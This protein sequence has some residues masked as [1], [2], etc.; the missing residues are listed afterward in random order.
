[1]T[2]TN[3]IARIKVWTRFVGNDARNA[4]HACRAP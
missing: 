2:D 3:R 4:A 1:M